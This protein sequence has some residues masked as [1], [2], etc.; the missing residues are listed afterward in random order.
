M[1]D[2]VSLDPLIAD[3][4]ANRKYRDL[5]IPTA[6][7]R[8]LL[9]KELPNHRN[10][11]DAVQAVRKKLHNIV[12]GYLGDPDYPSAGQSLA[13]AFQSGNPEQVQAA[14]A[15]VL[16]VHAST[17]ERLAII[18]DFYPRLFAVTGQ[19]SS[20]LDLACGLNPLCFPWMGLPATTQYHAFDLHAPR[21]DFINQFFSLQGLAPLAV[22]QDILINP[23]G[24]AADVA[25]FF[26]EAHRFEQRQRGC[27][28][29]FWQ[30]LKVR[31][32]LVSLPPANLTGRHSLIEGHRQLVYN[33]LKGLPWPVTELLFENELVFCIDKGENGPEKG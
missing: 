24:Q 22:Q 29:P 14:C 25:F 15:A 21:V 11:K 6:T 16:S 17:K 12:A 9:D 28:R 31:W 30:A 2:N 27:N 13:A 26:K 19:P 18:T 10:P 8:D 4:L 1:P 20:I 7:L 5:G 3:I 32:L 23:P 33:N